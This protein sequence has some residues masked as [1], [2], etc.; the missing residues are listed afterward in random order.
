MTNFTTT[1]I[2][3][4]DGTSH[5]RVPALRLRVTDGPDA[6]KTFASRNERIVLGTHE[7]ADLVLADP[8]VSRFHCEIA[9]V[10]ERVRIRDLGSRNGTLVD[11]VSIIE[12]HLHVGA[13]IAIGATKLV[14]AVDQATV[15]VPLSSGDRLGRLV[16]RS[17][18]MRSVFARLERAAASD[19]TVLLEGETGTGKEA[20]AEEIHAA[21]SRRGKPFV[22]VDC[23]AIPLELMESELFGH[24]KGA[25]T[26]AHAERQGAF[27]AAHGGTLF[28]DEI[29][30]LAPTLQPKL[31]RALERREIKPLGRT[32]YQV[33]DVRVIAATHRDLRAEVNA[34]RFRADLFYR[35]AVVD[36]HLPALRERPEDLPLLVDHLLA[37]FG[38]AAARVKTPE[39]L[40]QL[41]THSWPGNVRELR[42]YLERCIA[43]DTIEPLA[44]DAKA[45][46][47]A[48][49]QAKE[50]WER[51]YLEELLSR[52]DNN[53]SAAS[54]AA[55]IDRKQLYKMLW[56]NGLR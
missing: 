11:S 56:R 36:V 5:A 44:V 22:V 20:A 43:L 49:R 2:H 38:A 23:G 52:H 19:S 32:A 37:A 6:G 35:L 24:D 12:A 4:P 10:G 29:G 46:G 26:G 54:R 55:G 15:Q 18:A 31:L 39:L 9:L 17:L 42:N 21:S 41:A 45:T 14:F 13:V 34:K 51:A 8:A 7:S 3:N 50:S 1:E 40:A 28:L 25:F 33:V 53:V 16:G 48:M 30:E 27:A 47:G